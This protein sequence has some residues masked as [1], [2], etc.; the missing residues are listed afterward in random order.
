VVR[1]GISAARGECAV[2][3]RRAFAAAD[4][5]GE[6]VARAMLASVTP[7]V[8]GAWERLVREEAGLVLDFV[9]H[10]MPLPFRFGYAH[11]E[12]TGADRLADMAAAMILYGAPSLVVD[13]GTAV[14]YDLLSADGVFFTGVI[15]PGPEILARSLHDYTALLPLVEWWK[16]SP[17][18]VPS[19][20]EGAMLFGIDAGFCGVFRETVSRLLPL[21]GS[22]PRL[23]A[24]GGFAERFAPPSGFDFAIDPFLTLKGIGLL[25]AATTRKE[26]TGV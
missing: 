21:L 9:R 4:A 1:G 23:V 19:D 11:P 12:T 5:T 22:N 20:T 2:A 26:A 8:N 17:P 6:V 18:A 24:T 13:I 3:I 14:T 15:G 16:K 7:A 25:S 10:D